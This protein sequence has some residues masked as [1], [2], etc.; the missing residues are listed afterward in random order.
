MSL[1]NKDES[2]WA[3]ITR[4]FKNGPVVR[5]R[6]AASS[7]MYEPQGTARAYK[8]ELSS[9]YVNSLASYGQYERLARYADYSEMEYCLISSTCI[10]VPDG[11]KTIKELADEYGLDKEFIVYSYDHEKGQIVPAIAKQAR[12]TRTDHCWKVTFDNGKEIIGTEDHRL[13]L[14]DGSYKMIKDLKKGDSM[15]PFHRKSFRSPNGTND[16]KHYQY[17]YVMTDKTKNGWITEHKLIAEWATGRDMVKGEV[18]HHKNFKK[19]DNNPE[20][21]QIMTLEDH[22]RLHREIFN[23]HKWDKEKNS[24]WIEKFKKDHSKFMTDNNPAERRDIT[25][26]KIL[27]V[28]EKNGFNLYSTAEFFS[29]DPNVLKR[30]LKKYSFKNWEAFAKAYNVGWK[31]AG[32]DNGGEKN[33]RFDSSL[34]Y[35]MICDAFVKGMIPRTLAEKLNTTPTKIK[36]RVKDFGFKSASDFCKNYQNCKVVSVEYYGFEDLYDLTV[37]NYKNFA[38]DSVISHNTPEIAS[39]IDIYADEVTAVDEHGHMISIETENEEI[40]EILETLFFDILNVE[41]NLHSWIRN[42]CKYGDFVMF[43][44]A[45]ETNGILNLLPIPINEIEREEGYDPNNPFAF[46]F[47]WLTQGNMILEAWQIIHFRLLGNDNFLP[48]GSS[49]IEPARRVWRQLILIEDAMLVYRIV[50]SPERRV[51]KIEVGNVKPDEIPRYMEQVKDGLKRN[52]IINQTTGRVDLRYNPLSVD[53]DYFLPHRDG[54]GSLIETLPGGSFTGDIEDV[55]YIQNKMFAALKIP[56]SYLGYEGDVGSKATLAQEDVRFSRTIQRM[57]KIM[58]SELTK[59]AV[60]HLY[61]LGYR[62]EDLVDYEIKM[63]NPSTIAEQQKLELWRVKLEIAGSAQEGMLDK[64]TVWKDLFGFSDHKI[65][66]IQDG[67]KADKLFQLELDGMSLE[68]DESTEETGDIPAAAG[69]EELP[70]TLGGEAEE[71][72]EDSYHPEN[73]DE[74]MQSINPMI[75]IDNQDDEEDDGEE[76]NEE[77]EEDEEDINEDGDDIEG[78]NPG[79]EGNEAEISVSFGKDLFATGE[80]SYNHVFGTEKQAASDPFDM[81]GRNRMITRPFSEAADPVGQYVQASIKKI[82]ESQKN[83]SNIDNILMEIKNPKKSSS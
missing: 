48:Y 29:T 81:K 4:L 10:A 69:E 75:L 16:E 79:S 56:K 15:M 51:F 25:F 45:S 27:Q 9:L 14:R 76:I 22:S 55:Q 39:A 49:I 17:A 66:E 78:Y 73:D 30:K 8:K 44:D 65:S 21:L 61:L 80:N 64:V 40:K 13:M 2:I 33:P 42:L 32:W 52:K 47:R 46:R 34:T 38:T 6:I 54:K 63:S 18:V 12:K 50:R 11:Y 59:I 82:D 58:I 19:Y 37:D 35:Q 43:V 3:Q 57:Q 68:P 26:P 1:K 41:F 74:L 77:N 53:E 72:V 70:D 23:G 24:E 67:Q 5:H 36:N 7:K 71:P 83:L 28:A 31:N 62:G 20:N 60:I